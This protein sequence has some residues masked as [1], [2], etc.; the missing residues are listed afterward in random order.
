MAGPDRVT[1][2]IRPL[3]QEI[4]FVPKIGATWYAAPWL[5]SAPGCYVCVK[6]YARMRQA[7]RT[8]AVPARVVRAWIGTPP[9]QATEP[10]TRHGNRRCG[11]GLAW[12][13]H[14]PR[15]AKEPQETRRAIEGSPH[16]QPETNKQKGAVREGAGRGVFSKTSQEQRVPAH[17]QLPTYGATQNTQFIISKQRTSPVQPNT[18]HFHEEKHLKSKTKKV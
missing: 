4:I 14:R 17:P 1:K 11:Y 12:S 7:C 10:Y 6:R 13:G 8:F 5:G 9:Y 2:R 16:P 15:S 3:P 18:Q